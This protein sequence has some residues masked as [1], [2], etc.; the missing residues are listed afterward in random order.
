MRLQFGLAP[1]EGVTDL[2]VRCWFQLIGQVDFLGTPFLRVT[3]T[4]PAHQIPMDFYPEGRLADVIPKP[5]IPQVMAAKP[6]A[7]LRVADR[8][9]DQFPWVDLN[10]GCP[11]SNCFRGGAGSQL[12]AE[13]ERLDH[14]IQTLMSELGPESVS[15][16]MRTGIHHSDELPSLLKV[17]KPYKL[18]RV[19]V[20][21][22]TRAARYGGNSD[23]NAVA[24]ASEFLDIPVVG[25]GDIF[26]ASHYRRLLEPITT[27]GACIIGRGALRNPWI[28]WELKSGQTQSID[29]E[30]LRWSL[31]TLAAL[32]LLRAEDELALFDLLRNGLLSVTCGSDADLWQS[33]FAMIGAYWGVTQPEQLNLPPKVLGRI[34]MLW[35]YWRS[36]LPEVF[37]EPRL[38]RLKTFPDMMTRIAE[39]SK[40]WGHDSI[41]LSHQSKLD[42]IY[43]SDKKKNT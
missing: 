41:P 26:S 4:W 11:S 43:S 33:R 14:F 12:L 39:I 23:W 37:F 24:V 31:G 38:L 32:N 5:V 27:I 18:K 7:F 40:F 10:C 28:F 34:K 19:T 2:S 22:R 8:L 17:L 36:S 35:N 42:W 21:G 15:V 29:A 13:P 3:D 30:V 6:D 9:L 16:K 20:H 25:S 1:M